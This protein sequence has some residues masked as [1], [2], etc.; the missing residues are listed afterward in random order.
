[1]VSK[2]SV[3]LTVRCKRIFGFIF[4]IDFGSFLE[5]LK[6]YHDFICTL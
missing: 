1:M 5:R 2:V 6:G 3:E 4:L